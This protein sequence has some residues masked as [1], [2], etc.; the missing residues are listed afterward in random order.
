[1]VTEIQLYFIYTWKPIWLFINY[2]AI[3]LVVGKDEAGAW[4]DLYIE[5]RRS[6]HW[7]LHDA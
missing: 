7:T 5:T 3:L 2:N 6:Y 1:M 4:L